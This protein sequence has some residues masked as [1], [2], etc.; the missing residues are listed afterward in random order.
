MNFLKGLFTKGR[1]TSGEIPREG[2]LKITDINFSCFAM[3][4][5]GAK[6]LECQDSIG[7]YDN[8]GPNF[9]FF[10]VFDGHGSSGKEASSMA[11]DLVSSYIEKRH[12]EITN[13][14][15]DESRINFLK[16]IFRYTENVFFC[17][18]NQG[19]KK[20]DIDMTMSGTTC[21]SCFIQDGTC[22]C[23]NVGDS[24]AILGRFTKDKK[25][26]IELSRDHKP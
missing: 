22:Y 17:P 11:S 7:I 1:E 8:Y 12:K 25:F 18:K 15:T 14:K 13:F 20:S 9:Y 5:E 19:L 3:M 4:G 6:K 10:C 23:S 2:G 21:I 26:A 24:R 16:N